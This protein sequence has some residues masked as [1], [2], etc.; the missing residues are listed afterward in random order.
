MKEP[1]GMAKVERKEG[2][3]G[4]E[5]DITTLVLCIEW[6]IGREERKRG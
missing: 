4:K 6:M 3:E 2:A 1:I 5:I